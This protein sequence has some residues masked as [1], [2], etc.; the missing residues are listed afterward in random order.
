MKYEFAPDRMLVN[1]VLA[2]EQALKVG[3]NVVRKAF[4]I[5]QHTIDSIQSLHAVKNAASVIE[6][7]RQTMLRLDEFEDRLENILPQEPKEEITTEIIP[8]V[9]IDLPSLER[10]YQRVV[11]DGLTD[12]TNFNQDEH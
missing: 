7:R 4:L 8:L 6:D 10:E 5:G 2:T 9:S 12:Q 1:S 11:Q 3:Q